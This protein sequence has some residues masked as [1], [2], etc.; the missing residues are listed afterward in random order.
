MSIT[1]EHLQERRRLLTQAE[2]DETKGESF[3]LKDG[4]LRL[5]IRKKFFIVRVERH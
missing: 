2:S 1:S 3:K 5:D 4:M